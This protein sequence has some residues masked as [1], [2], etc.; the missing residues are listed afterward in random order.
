MSRVIQ[1]MS[2]QASVSAIIG[3]DV[4]NDPAL[5][6]KAMPRGVVSDWAD[7]AIANHRHTLRQHALDLNIDVPPDFEERGVS[8][9]LRFFAKKGERILGM[10]SMVVDATSHHAMQKRQLLACE[11]HHVQVNEEARL[12]GVASDLISYALNFVRNDE[13]EPPR[14]FVQ[15]TAP[16]AMM[17][18]LLRRHPFVRQSDPFATPMFYVM[19]GQEHRR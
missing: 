4:V 14:V 8:E 3:M 11:L 13:F 6:K 12:K 10:L 18:R 9:N 1:G 5:T 7:A 15:A 17:D 2:D 19:Q 16:L